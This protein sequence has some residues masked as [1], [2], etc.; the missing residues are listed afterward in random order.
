MILTIGTAQFGL[1]YGFKNK[2]IKKKDLKKILKT[3]Q[4]NKLKY[5]DTAISYGD[6][7]KIVGEACIKNFK[8][9]SKLPPLPN[10]YLNLDA[11]VNENVNLSLKRLG[12]DSLYGLLIHKSDNFFGSE[13]KKLIEALHTLKSNGLVKKIGVSIYDP[14]ECEKVLKYTK[15]DIV[16]APL[17]LVDRRI[18]SSGLLSKLHADKIEVHTRSVFLQGLLQMPRIK[19][20]KYFEKWSTIWD[21]WYFELKKNNISPTEACLLYP[22]S[23]REVDRVIVGVD[24]IVQ[25]K[26]IIEKSKLHKSNIDWSFM[27]SNDQ[28]LI[29][30]SN[31]NKL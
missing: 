16:Q 9:V 15:L 31:W 29:N 27:T 8:V 18:V 4:S 26:E 24:N 3:L 7:E 1:K 22:L 17:N 13:G 23:L 20:P 21:K 12:I 2:K 5:F 11:W 19:M 25:L 10:K 28:M 30:P 14:D 6:S